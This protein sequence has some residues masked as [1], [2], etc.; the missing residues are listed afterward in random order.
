MNQFETV[1]HLLV[2]CTSSV[3]LMFLSV[4]TGIRGLQRRTRCSA[5][6]SQHIRHYSGSKS[7]ALS[8]R[9]HINPQTSSSRTP[10]NLQAE[11]SFRSR[12]LFPLTQVV[13]LRARGMEFLSAPNMYYNAL[14]QN[15]KTAKIKVKEDLDR[16]QVRWHTTTTSMGWFTTLLLLSKQYTLLSLKELKIL[17][18]FDDKGYLLQI[19][20]KPVQDRPT[21]FLEAIQHNNHSVSATDHSNQLLTQMVNGG[22]LIMCVHGGIHK[23]VVQFF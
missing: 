14:R 17:L 20:T 15:L 7:P 5:H 18:D 21:L 12:F 23:L 4:F 3:H 11:A 22:L 10:P 9:F 19:F 1:G 13:N 8:C 2:Y 16:L 6:R